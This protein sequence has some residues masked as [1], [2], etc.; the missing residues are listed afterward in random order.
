MSP[1]APLSLSC[2][3]PYDVVVVGSGFAGWAAAVTARRDFEK[4]LLIGERGDLVWEAGRG[5]C[6]DI[7]SHEH[8]LWEQLVAEVARRTPEQPPPGGHCLDGAIAEVVATDLLV[9]SGVAVLYYAIPIGVVDDGE[10][11]AEL[12]LATKAG[13]RRVRGYRWVDATESGLLVRLADPAA[14]PRNPTS[15]AIRLLLQRAEWSDPTPGRDSQLGLTVWPAERVWTVPVAPNDPAWRVRLPAALADLAERLGDADETTTI[16]HLSFEPVTAYQETTDGAD[17]PTCL[18]PVNLVPATPAFTSSAVQTLADRLDLGLA[19]SGVLAAIPADRLPARDNIDTDPAAGPVATVRADVCVVGVGT[20]GALAA[21]AAARTG[22]R[23][24]GV[25]PASFVGGIGTGGGIHS[26]SFGVPGGLQAEVDR[27]TRALMSQYGKGLLGDGPFNPWA[28]MITLERLQREA[29][30]D[31]R[32]GHQLYHVETVRGR[33][34]AVHVAGPDGPLRVEAASFVDGTGDGDLSALAG[35]RCTLGRQGDGLTHAYSQSS[36]VLRD[37]AGRPRMGVVNFDAG[38][39]DPTDPDDLTRARLVGILQYLLPRYQ[40]YGRPTYV[41]PAI[42]LRQGRQVVTEYVLTL[43][44]QINWRRFDDVIGYTASHYENHASDCEFE[45]DESL[46]WVWANRQWT[47]PIGCDLNYRMLVPVGLHNVWVASRCAGVSQ[48]AH[49]ATRMQRDVQRLGEVAGFAAAEAARQGCAANALDLSGL[50]RWLDSTGA[51]ERRA[52]LVETEF[53]RIGSGTSRLNDLP[54]P[55]ARRRALELLDAGMPGEGMWWLSRHPETAR[56]EVHAR[57]DSPEPMVSWLAA[58]VAAWWGDRAAEPRLLRAIDEREYGFGDGWSWI[59]GG[60]NAPRADEPADPMRW[61]YVVP[62]WLAAIGLLRRCGTA[63]CLPSLTG[64]LSQPRHG[65][66]TVTTVATTLARL[67]TD[68]R[69]DTET[70][71]RVGGLVPLL[72]EARLSGTVDNPRRPIGRHSQVALSGNE[73]AAAAAG[74]PTPYGNALEDNAWQAPYAVGKLRTA[75]GMPLDG[76][77]ERYRHDERALV[78][79][80]FASLG[81]GPAGAAGLA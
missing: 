21:L 26:Y 2:P 72:E 56:A 44:D 77:I 19:A 71:P 1:A 41:A 24:I 79:R 58:G 25:E 45:S 73:P 14:H 17:A 74:E 23:V 57:L 75:L 69:L 42:G 65:L 47:T 32:L 64:L 10:R 7:G 28:K 46:F 18:L 81:D 9:R 8:E 49:H 3:D 16:S 36:G 55:A 80:A 68:R 31:L 67:V 27:E 59:P 61:M 52:R 12:E 43:D 13:P 6:T 53:G 30:V 37:R 63:A 60:Y 15:A 78:R 40:Y 54:E 29:G 35:A 50:R 48:D 76:S 34:V 22:S 66:N 4:V 20:G 11:I 38:F 39:C 70:W 33:V 5:F 51:L 62:N